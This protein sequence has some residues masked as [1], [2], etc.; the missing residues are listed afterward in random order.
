MKGKR[1]FVLGMQDRCELCSI[2]QNSILKFLLHIRNISHQYAAIDVIK[3]NMATEQIL[4]HKTFSENLVFKFA[5]GVQ[6][7]SYYYFVTCLVVF[8]KTLQQIARI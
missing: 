7:A 5:S 3:K 8:V 2:F 4:I 6:S 1:I